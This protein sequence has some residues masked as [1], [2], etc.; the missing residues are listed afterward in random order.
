MGNNSLDFRT[1]FLFVKEVILIFAII[2]SLIMLTGTVSGVTFGYYLG[3]DAAFKSIDPAH[4]SLLGDSPELILSIVIGML[5]YL[6]AS[7]I[8]RELEEKL[9][10]LF[11]KVNFKDI[12]AGFIGFVSGLII[13]NL[14]ILLPALI[15]I[16]TTVV[17]LP[18]FLQPIVPITKFFIPLILNLFFGYIFRSFSPADVDDNVQ[19]ERTVYIDTS[20]LIDGRIVDI[21]NTGFLMGHLLIPRFVLNELH[22][23]SDSNDEL[24]RNR[25][26][27]GLSILE[28]MKRLYPKQVKI[29]NEDAVEVNGV[30]EKLIRVALATG[31]VI[32]TNDYNLNKVASIQNVQVL[33]LNDLSKALKPVVMPGEILPIYVLKKGKESGQGVGYLPDGTMVVVEDGGAAVGNEMNT[34]VTSM[35]QTS[36]GRMIFTRIHDA[37]DNVLNLDEKRKTDSL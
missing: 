11:H 10:R 30:D 18:E 5:G 34:I 24:K 9:Q 31:S 8:T 1:I 27:R 32:I 33:N 13:A 6:I 25:G 4:P 21:V 36:A 17:N 22:M 37:T 14:T 23:L 15:F 29:T 7:L 2:R 20:V 3:Q 12:V 26:R 35:I 28:D 19:T 16:N